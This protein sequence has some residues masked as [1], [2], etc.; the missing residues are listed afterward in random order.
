MGDVMNASPQ[1]LLIYAQLM[2]ILGMLEVKWPSILQGLF[3]AMS[4]LTHIAPKVVVF[5]A[6]A[7]S[8]SSHPS[9]ANL[10]SSRLIVFASCSPA[11]CSAIVAS[12]IAAA[13]ADSVWLLDL[14]P[15]R[16]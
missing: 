13:A 10:S 15:G 14:S 5:P 12:N 1:A 8:F 4:W 7:C 11:A 2:S 6:V 16:F 9:A 3:K